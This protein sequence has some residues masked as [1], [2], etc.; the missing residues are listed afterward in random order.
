M[1]WPKRFIR[2]KSAKSPPEAG[3]ADDGAAVFV[4]AFFGKSVEDEKNYEHDA[5][6]GIEPDKGSIV[7]QAVNGLVD[8]GV[9]NGCEHDGLLLEDFQI[10]DDENG[11]VGREKYG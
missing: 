10:T 5:G 2:M 3:A 9:V 6:D 11:N 4:A 8:G 1:N 7:H